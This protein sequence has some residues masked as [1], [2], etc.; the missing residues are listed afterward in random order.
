MEM[1]ELLA[2]MSVAEKLKCTT[3][4]S[5]TSSG[6][7][8]SVAEH[9][10]RMALLAMAVAD[11]FSELDMNKVIQMCLIHDLG[12]AV[13]GDI[14]SFYKTADDEYVEMNALNQVLGCVSGSLNEKLRALFKEMEQLESPEAKLYKCLDKCEV[15]LQHN[16]ASLDTWIELEFSLNLTHGKKECDE[17]DYMQRLRERLRQDTMIKLQKRES[18]EY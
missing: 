15:V 8:E 7:Q 17:F 11:E 4:H 16:E 6:R 5:W 14:P 1:N 10:W 9:S 13:T 3:R 12:E 2:F 18:Y